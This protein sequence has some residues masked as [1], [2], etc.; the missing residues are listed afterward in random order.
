MAL[1][2]RQQDDSSTFLK[3]TR[4]RVNRKILYKASHSKMIPAN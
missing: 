3:N 4:I 1:A 2:E